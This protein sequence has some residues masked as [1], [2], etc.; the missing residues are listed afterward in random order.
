MTWGPLKME[1]HT[2]SCRNIDSYDVGSS[3]Y[4][5]TKAEGYIPPC[6]DISS[7]DVATSSLEKT[8][9]QEQ[10]LSCH[11]KQS[12]CRDIMHLKFKT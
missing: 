9:N 10:P 8:K 1:A 11:Y 7:Y 5:K 12:S 3:S 6:R 2:L 4:V